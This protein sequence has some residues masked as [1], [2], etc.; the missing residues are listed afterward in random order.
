[1]RLRENCSVRAGRLFPTMGAWTETTNNQHPWVSISCAN[2]A[3][4][5][6]AEYAEEFAAPCLRP[7]FISKLHLNPNVTA[8]KETKFYHCRWDQIHLVQQ[9]LPAA[10]SF[11]TAA[12][13]ATPRLME[14][15]L[16][17]CVLWGLSLSGRLK[18]AESIN[19]K[20]IYIKKKRNR[21]IIKPKQLHWQ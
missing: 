9:C 12:S 17:T 3:Q 21:N 19:L 13:A 4:E 2:H 11:C 15:T 7:G 18:H 1:M 6:S 8:I 14:T 20:C 16:A 10:I 5:M